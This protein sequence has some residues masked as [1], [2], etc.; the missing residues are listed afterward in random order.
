MCGQ[1]MRQQGST[2]AEHRL[3]HGTGA[4]TTLM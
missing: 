2:T 1:R 4:D 3:D